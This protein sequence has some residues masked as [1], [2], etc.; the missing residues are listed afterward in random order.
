[1]RWWKMTPGRQCGASR[2]VRVSR[3]GVKLPSTR[4]GEYSK[5]LS[6][7][8]YYW[9]MP[10]M[11]SVIA[12]RKSPYM[13]LRCNS[14]LRM[15]KIHT[16]NLHNFQLAVNQERNLKPWRWFSR[17]KATCKETQKSCLGIPDVAR[18]HSN[19]WLMQMTS[20]GLERQKTSGNGGT[21]L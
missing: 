1:M 18:H 16:K 20:P 8:K 3:P 14:L 7:R 9:S 11:A 2:C 19:N 10:L 21:A 13:T 4:S 6:S 12:T 17:L 15:L 5:T